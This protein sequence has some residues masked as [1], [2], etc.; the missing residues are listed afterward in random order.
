MNKLQKINFISIIILFSTIT[1]FSQSSKEAIVSAYLLNF[2]KYINWENEAKME[3]FNIVIICN[4][5]KNT[6]IYKALEQNKK[7]KNIKVT[8]LEKPINNILINAQM[9]FLA[10][11]KEDY[12]NEIFDFIEYKSILLVSENQDNERIMMVNLYK[13]GKGEI[14]F[15]INKLNILNQKLTINEKLLLLGGT[16]VD[17]AELYMS[18]KESL[19]NLEKEIESYHSQFKELNKKIFT[20]KNK[21]KKQ[22]KIIDDQKNDH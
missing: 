22:N 14:S 21:L 17:I 1:A 15:K 9:I 18:S 8:I 16:E 3:S 10:S 7:T 19:R 2:A 4:K 12:Y 5:S 13:T 20:S 6:N 11:E